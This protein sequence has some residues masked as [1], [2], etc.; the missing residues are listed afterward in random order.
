MGIE[1]KKIINNW[2]IP[3]NV[4]AL[5]SALDIFNVETYE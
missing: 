3:Q 4:E 1:S 5:K 2:G